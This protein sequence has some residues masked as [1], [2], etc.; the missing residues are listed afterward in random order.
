[1]ATESSQLLPPAPGREDLTAGLRQPVFRI[2]F[3]DAMTRRLWRNYIWIFLILLLGWVLK[4]MT[5]LPGT[6]VNGVIER[7]EGRIWS[8]DRVNLISAPRRLPI[9]NR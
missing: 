6:A 8:R 1:M 9:G 2:G 3:I 4:V 5:L 7:Q